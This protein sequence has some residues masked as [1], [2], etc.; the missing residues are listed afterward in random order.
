MADV[1]RADIVGRD[2]GASSALRGYSRAADVAAETTRRLA[3]AQ[4]AQRRAAATSA[5]ATVASAKADQILKDASEEAIAATV[6]QR[7]ET[8]KLGRQSAETAGEVGALSGAAGAG[9]GVAGGGLAALAGAAVVT[10][11][12]IATL[13]VGLGGLGLAALSAGKNSKQLKTELEPLKN[14]FVTFGK[15]L[16]PILL[17]DFAKAAGLASAVLGDIEPV[18][19][20]T[21][22]ALGGMFDQIGATFQSGTWQGFFAF[23]ERT[24]GPDIQLLT[25]NITDLM[26]ALPPLVEQLQPA[27]TA[28]LTITDTVAKLAGK[29]ATYNQSVD[30]TSQHENFLA[31][32][33]DMLRTV[34]F[35]PGKGLLAALHL[36]G[37][38]GPE[39]AKGVKLTGD[40]ANTATAYVKGLAT[41]VTALNTAESKSLDTQLAYSN[42]LIATK[43]DAV[44]LRNAL[45]ASHDEIGLQTAVQRASFS[46]ANT[47]IADLEQSAKQAVASGR[48]AQGAA[49]AI[50]QGL[51]ILQQAASKNRAYWQ[52][53]QTL[54][55]WLDKLRL[56]RPI[57]EKINVLGIG[58]WSA[59]A[60]THAIGQ[61]PGPFSAGGRIPGY[62]GGDRV[63]ALLEG[64]EAVVPKHL[65]PVLAPF[66]KAHGVPGFQ[67]GGIIGG[68]GGNVAGLQPWSRHNMN[69]AA[70]QI[71]AGIGNAM[72]QAFAS[73][74]RSLFVPGGGAVGGDAL[75]N[76]ALARRMFPWGASQ[77]FPFVELVMAESG[78]NRFARNPSSGAYGIAQALP[79]TKYPFAGQAAGGSHAGAQLAWMFSY[80]AGRYG[81]P[82]AAWAHEVS[83]HW[84]DQG[85]YL[86]PGLS[87]AYNGTGRPEPVG[88]TGN[89]YNINVTA[90][91]GANPKEIGRQIVS[92]IKSFEQGSG[93]GWRRL[94]RSPKRR[95]AARSPAALVAA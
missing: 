71:V 85:G 16:Q 5:A 61:G 33:T 66:L 57:L 74:S 11:P 50:Q 27:A 60:A 70:G 94:W 55:N 69:A 4:E 13:G 83:A 23:M 14:D 77:W 20:A 24:A 39:A 63:P 91:V 12:V 38:T 88:A 37:I 15:S 3:D 25:R 44:N 79:P 22:K 72:A 43:N 51:P 78:F 1:L 87:L 19:A 35:A 95:T 26:M 49:R 75:A 31:K 89:T 41:A 30:K 81:T 68:Y 21:G 34:L 48:G 56:E 2:M 7:I 47:Y 53:V 65:T 6:A 92:Y 86:P 54:K 59:A 90:G 84:Y 58:K 64:G 40:N 18:A 9:G 93:A 32:T 80:I 17:Y 73:A 42:A 76:Q 28:L 67:A 8:E 82:A 45:K 10:A 46:A 29:L 36:L 62:G 52:E